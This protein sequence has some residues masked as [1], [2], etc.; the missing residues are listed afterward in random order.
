MSLRQWHEYGWLRKVSPTAHMVHSLFA[1]ADR[2]I[3]DGSL[4]G[5]SADGRFGH[6]YN[7]VR[8]L[9]E[10]ALHVSGNRLDKSGGGHER[11]L[12]SLEHTIRGDWALRM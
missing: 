7:A 3:A 9:A 6:A 2:E 5:I 8:V 10:L 1:T 12:E 11:A 4:S